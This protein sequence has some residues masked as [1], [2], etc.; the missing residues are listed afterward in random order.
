MKC[1]I[2]RLRHKLIHAT[3]KQG[4][5]AERWNGDD[6]TGDGGYQRLINAVCE[7]R[8]TRVAFRVCNLLKGEQHEVSP[9]TGISEQQHGSQN[10]FVRLNVRFNEGYIA[11]RTRYTGWLQAFLDLG[12]FGN[13][14]DARR[15]VG[16]RFN[17]RNDLLGELYVRNRAAKR[18]AQGQALARPR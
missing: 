7:L 1:R 8:R 3:T 5:R 14:N 18:H 2:G 17:L 9:E 10:W 4:E 6:Q 11:V 16:R 12:Q 13:T 15:G